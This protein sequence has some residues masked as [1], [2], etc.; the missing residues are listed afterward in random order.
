MK[1]QEASHSD[2]RCNALG[3]GTLTA[4]LS[5]RFLCATG[6]FAHTGNKQKEIIVKAIRDLT[7]VLICAGTSADG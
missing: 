3:T 4:A 6:S 5:V 1:A 7:K 2:R